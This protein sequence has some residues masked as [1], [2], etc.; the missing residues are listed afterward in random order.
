MARG[1]GFG[2]AAGDLDDDGDLDLYLA[3]YGPD[4]LW[5]NLGGGRFE[6]ATAG[7]GLGDP[8]WGSAA[9]FFDYD[10]DGRLD[11]FVANYLDFAPEKAPPCFAASSRR[12]YC[13]PNAF[14]AGGRTLFSATAAAAASTTPASAPASPPSP[15]RAWGWPSP[16][17]S[18]ATAA[19]DLFVANDGEPNELWR[20][21]GKG[22]FTSSASWPAPRSTPTASRRPAWELAVADF[23]EDGDEDLYLTHLV[24]EKNTLYVNLGD[25]SFADRSAAFGLLA[26]SLPFTSFGTAFLDLDRDGWLDLVTVS[27]GVKQID[28]L[29]AAG[30]PGGA[31]PAEAAF[32]QRSA[33]KVSKNG[34][35][36]A[37]KPS[38]GSR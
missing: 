22:R 35:S 21:D 25:G 38:P 13:G 31:R 2:V 18:T 32:P 37:A 8:R 9:T 10:R 36:A 34:A 14:Q 16:S 12:D 26:P 3:N 20:N 24:R 28:E 5:R 27:G 23:D 11:L 19:P 15:V 7:A 17:I 29:L 6:D 4:Q 1:Y 33:A 30:R